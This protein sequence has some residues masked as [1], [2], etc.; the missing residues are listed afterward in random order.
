MAQQDIGRGEAARVAMFLSGD[1]LYRLTARKRPSAQRRWLT[2]RGW[3]FELDGFG[4][5]VVLREEAERRML[6]APVRK[7]PKVRVAAL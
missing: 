6:S 4:R 1:E 7:E 3:R 5:P 2:A